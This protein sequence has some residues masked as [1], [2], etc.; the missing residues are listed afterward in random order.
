MAIGLSNMALGPLALAFA[1]KFDGT[2]AVDDDDPVPA[3]GTMAVDDDDP[4]PAA[5][6]NLLAFSIILRILRNFHFLLAL[7]SL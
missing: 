7:M 5:A 1:P 3:V 2:M 4:V 6:A